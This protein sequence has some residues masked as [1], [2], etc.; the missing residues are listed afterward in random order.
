[1]DWSKQLKENLVAHSSLHVELCWLPEFVHI[2]WH[3]YSLLKPTTEPQPV[4]LV[5]VYDIYVHVYLPGVLKTGFPEVLS[6]IQLIAGNLSGHNL[7]K[8]VTFS[9]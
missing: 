2:L 1:M 9:G 5:S 3:T 4:A 7:L 8:A 6:R